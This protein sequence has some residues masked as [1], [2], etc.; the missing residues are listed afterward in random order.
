MWNVGIIDSSGVRLYY[1]KQLRQNDIGVLTTGH[2]VVPT[3]IIPEK[4]D[5]WHI[6]GYCPQH[7]TER[8]NKCHPN[9]LICIC[10]L[11]HQCKLNI[12]SIVNNYCSYILYSYA[13]TE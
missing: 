8:V 3:M 1:T 4:Q 13:L 12:K 10:V 5:L 6:Y 9:P 7:C 2:P 11:V